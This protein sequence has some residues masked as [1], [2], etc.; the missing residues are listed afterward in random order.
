MSIPVQADHDLANISNSADLSAHFCRNISSA[1]WPSPMKSPTRNSSNFYFPGEPERQALARSQRRRAMVEE[2]IDAKRRFASLL[3][4]VSAKGGWLTSVAGDRLV[5]L[6]TPPG[7]SLPDD[8]RKAG[9]DVVPD[10]EG[11]RILPTARTET[12][13]IEGSTRSTIAVTHA[14]ICKVLRY[15]FPLQRI[16]QQHQQQH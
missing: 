5:T 3:K 7:S 4:Y 14:G 8:L 16:A 15:V 9:Y 2:T 6:E 10:G 13:L 11:Q 1:A 12:I